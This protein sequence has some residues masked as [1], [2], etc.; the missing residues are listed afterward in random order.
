MQSFESFQ[1]K[2]IEEAL[3]SINDLEKYLLEL[4]LSPDNKSVLEKVFRV[5]HSLKGGGAM[6][7][8]ERLSEFTH[9]MENI[10]DLIR[11]GKLDVSV[12]ILSVTLKSVDLLRALLDPEHPNPES[13][14]QRCKKMMAQVDEVIKEEAHTML[15]NSS[16]KSSSYD[17][18]DER[19]E[20]EIASY[21]IHFYPGVEVLKNG[22][23]ILYLLDELSQMGETYIIARTKEI[24]LLEDITSKSCYLFWDIFIATTC[25][26][27][28]LMDIFIFVEDESVIEINELGKTDI[29]ID[30]GFA[31]QLE[32]IKLG[33]DELDF[34]QLSQLCQEIGKVDSENRNQNR[35]DNNRKSG[36][37]TDIKDRSLSLQY[38]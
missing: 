24:P 13:L 31:S 10:Y 17:E 14:K 8:F 37:H 33:N 16:L 35:N 18:C 21:Y 7:G 29:F 36:A 9:R 26:R 3:D 15:L 6:F 11:E 12:N 28:A 22:T 19:D 23:N 38:G 25:G 5:M 2:F 20:G 32:K 30:K 4:E 27:D 34:E 1:Y